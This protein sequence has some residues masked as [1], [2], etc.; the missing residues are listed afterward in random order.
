MRARTRTLGLSLQ[1][2]AVAAL[3]ALTML[4]PGSLAQTPVGEEA[5]GE[6]HP[7][8]IHSGTCDQL[9][10]VVAPLTDVS[11]A[12]GEMVG[13]D[14]AFPVVSSIT[15]VDMPLQAIIDGGHAINVH[16][17]AEEIDVYIACGDIGGAVATSEDGRDS[18]FIGLGEL[19][20]S[21]YTGVAWLGADGEQ[22]D[23]SI[24]LTQIATT[25]SAAGTPVSEAA[26]MA[27]HPAHIHTGTC[28]ELGE[29]AYPLTDVAAVEGEM[30][31]PESAQLVESSISAVDA[32][33]ED[34]ID[35]NHALNVHLSGDEIGTYIAC[36]DIGGT[37]V[38]SDDG[39]THLFIGLGELNGSGYTGVAW[40]G[41]D[42]EQTEVSVRLIKPGTME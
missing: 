12:A 23:V 20:D 24:V 2:A 17:S 29:V 28:A 39:R 22:T 21:G 1:I 19:N 8:H 40:L 42:G 9:G 4:V 25:E 38:T 5:A 26:G 13:S 37:L 33:L 32:P 31:G 34:L 16:Q 15:T 10:D 3:A 7:A 41:A 11:P 27:A 6:A 36:G 30:M 18:L 35:G 14:A